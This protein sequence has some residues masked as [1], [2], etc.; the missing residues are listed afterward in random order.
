MGSAMVVPNFFRDVDQL[1]VSSLPG[2]LNPRTAR[3]DIIQAAFISNTPI[4]RQMYGSAEL[5]ILGQPIEMT[6]R[7]AS[8][9]GKDALVD[10]LIQK[11]ALPTAPKKDKLLGLVPMD[12]NQYAQYREYRA[13]QLGEDLNTPAMIEALSKMEP[14][15]AQMY[16]QKYTQKAS[17]LA[18]A[19]ILQGDPEI[20]KEAR[21]TKAKQFK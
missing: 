17:Q 16:V 15:M 5:D 11:N 6:S 3:E 19:K 18:K 4:I 14:G 10:V 12:D 7:V 1:I 13:K 9:A 8:I 20:L 21:E 2:V